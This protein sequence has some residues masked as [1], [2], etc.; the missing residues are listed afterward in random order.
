[1]KKTLLGVLLL[2]AFGLGVLAGT[3]IRPAQAD[4]TDDV[5]RMTVALEH[6]DRHVEKIADKIGR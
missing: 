2:G 5:H 3:G 6:I 4:R 1:M